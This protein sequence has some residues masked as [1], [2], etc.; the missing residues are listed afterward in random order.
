MG[1]YCQVH[2]HTFYFWKSKELPKILLAKN[3][4]PK[5]G[6]HQKDDILCGVEP[7]TVNITPQNNLKIHVQISPLDNRST[8]AFGMSFENV[9][10]KYT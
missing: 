1:S 6:P 4:L 5:L 3:R 2:E 10:S 7:Q 8:E 9:S